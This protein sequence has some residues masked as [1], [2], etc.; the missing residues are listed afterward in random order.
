MAGRIVVFGATGYTGRLV[1][2]ALVKRGVRPLLAGRSADRLAELASSL[3]GGFDT[4]VADVDRPE[5]VRALVSSG[6]VMV[7]TVGPFSKWGEPAVQAAISA[8]VPYLDST[9]EAPFI[10]SVFERHGRAAEAAGCGLLTAFGYDYVPGNLAGALALQEAGAA[11]VRVDVG[12]FMTGNVSAGGGMSG[13]TRASAGGVVFAPSFTWRD[14]RLQ[15]VRSAERVRSFDV[16]GR[17]REGFTIGGT[18][19]FALPRLSSSLREV[20]VYLGWFGPLSRVMQGLSAAVSAAERLPLPDLSAVSQRLFGSGSSGGP[21]ADARAKSRSHVVAVAADA[22]GRAL[23]TVHL[24]G[25]NGYTFTGDILAWGA[26]SALEH[27]LQGVGALG[28]VDGFGLERLR[29]GCAEV[30]LVRV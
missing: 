19:A 22:T 2:E 16:G 20:N 11:A 9:G 13:G 6:D 17:S 25:T 8:G 18:E 30:G 7:S 12:Y 21:D 28:P 27:G 26:H 1:S 23:A 29:A 24:E 14:G 15:T 3:G 10:R 5:T 4:A